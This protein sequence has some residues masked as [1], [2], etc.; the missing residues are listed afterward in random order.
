MDTIRE[1]LNEL[2]AF[3]SNEMDAGTPSDEVAGDIKMNI[4]CEANRTLHRIGRMVDATAHLPSD[5]PLPARLMS[6]KVAAPVDVPAKRALLDQVDELGYG[7]IDTT[8]ARKWLD[9]AEYA[10]TTAHLKISQK[11][12]L[13]KLK[14]GYMQVL[15]AKTIDVPKPVV[16]NVKRRNRNRE[17]IER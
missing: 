16:I 10:Q 14:D 9:L 11:D 1:N 2:F 17:R 6:G 15:D 4:D 3:A 7:A 13:Y 8:E 12:E 5:N